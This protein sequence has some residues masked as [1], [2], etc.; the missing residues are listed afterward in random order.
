[1]DRWCRGVRQLGH[2]RYRLLCALFDRT[3]H[4]WQKVAQWHDRREEYIKR[5]A[6]ALLWGLTVHDKRADDARFVEGLSF[7]KRA[8]ADE[9]HF[10]KKAVNMALRAT[11]KR[12]PALNEAALAVARRS[13]PLPI[14]R[15]A[16]SGRTRSGN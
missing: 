6:F 1:M 7:I 14:P 10:I 15:R 5:A 3:A 9:R 8:A 11:G 12:N 4:A 16:G 2:L 13:P